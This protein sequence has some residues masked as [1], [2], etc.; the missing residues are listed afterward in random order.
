MD[1]VNLT[2]HAVDIRRVDGT[3]LTVPPSGQVARCA[4]TR[5]AVES[6][7][8]DISCTRATFGAV[9]GLPA[10]VTGKIFIVSALVLNQCVGRTDVFAPG[11]AVRD[12][13]GKIVG[14][15]GLSAAPEAPAAPAP[16]PAPEAPAAPAPAAP[17]PAPT[18]EA[19]LAAFETGAPNSADLFEAFVASKGGD[20]A[21]PFAFGM[22]RRAIREGNWQKASMLLRDAVRSM[23]ANARR[24]EAAAKAAPKPLPKPPPVP[25]L[26]RMRS[27]TSCAPPPNRASGA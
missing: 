23:D 10:P 18:A 26:R 20:K 2:P 6:P 25:P 27:P 5:T 8:E 1:I 3:V 24:A 11:P 9:E 14:C 19:V 13:A 16:A 21:E 15:D 7:L 22:A 4:E 17:A 12:A